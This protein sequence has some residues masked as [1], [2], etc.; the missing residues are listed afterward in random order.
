MSDAPLSRSS[1][2]RPFAGRFDLRIN[3]NKYGLIRRTIKRVS[4]SSSKINIKK[5]RMDSNNNGKND[6][7]P[8]N[9]N[10]KNKEVPIFMVQRKQVLAPI[11]KW[12][13]PQQ[14]FRTI[15]EWKPPSLYDPL[16]PVQCK[17]LNNECWFEIFN[18]LTL[19]ELCNVAKVCDGI[20]LAAQ[21]YFEVMYTSLNLDWLIDDEGEK[22]TLQQAKRLLQCFGNFIS[23]LIVNTKQLQEADQVE[24]LLELIGKHCAG[25]LFWDIK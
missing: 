12:M 13:S 20:K 5:Y 15:K 23:K 18:H 8:I 16:K 25:I 11:R 2:L 6:D 22:F 21:K 3:K 10:V 19:N 14:P 7:K 17:N 24:Q 9:G 4:Q 1:R